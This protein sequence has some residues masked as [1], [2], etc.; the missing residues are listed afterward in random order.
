LKWFAISKAAGFGEAYSK[1]TTIICYSM[2]QISIAKGRW[3]G[4]IMV[5]RTNLVVLGFTLVHAI[6]AKYIAVLSVV[7]TQDRVRLNVGG[8][9]PS[10]VALPL[11]LKTV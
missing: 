5:G 4:K 9:E 8:F 6:Q 10:H 2:I 7:M 1:S 11:Y 3:E